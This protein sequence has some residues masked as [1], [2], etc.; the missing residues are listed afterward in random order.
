M[1]RLCAV[2]M[3]AGADKA[4]NIA[5]AGRLIDAAM[6]DR[7]DL[8]ALPEIW[9]CIGGD[10]ANRLAQ[11]EALPPAESGAAGGPAYEFLRAAAQ[12]HRVHV[13]GGS[14]IERGEG[15]RLRNTT[16]V[17]DPDGREIA[18]YSKIHLFDTTAH[19]Q[20]FGESRAF[21]A[22]RAIVTYQAHGLTIGCAICYDLRFAELFLAL[23]RRGAE[24]I[25]LPSAFT[26]Q[27]GMDHFVPLLRARAIETQCWI[28][29]PALFGRHLEGS[30]AE[31]RWSYGHS[32]IADP[33]GEVVAHASAGP[34]WATAAI[35]RALTERIRR[36]MPVLDHHVLTG[37]EA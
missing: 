12:R 36:E 35:D 9:T 16:V 18:R 14:L 6:A 7:P 22:G 19:G 8:I 1:M 34:G 17:F 28:A 5:E 23:R 30:R 2:Q 3:N 4:A 24:V 27:T 32:M 10:R 26:L 33:W 25:V 29:A 31:E 13:H 11:A 15:D 37:T 20:V 21:D